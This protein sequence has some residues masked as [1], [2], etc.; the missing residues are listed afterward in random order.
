MRFFY[1]SQAI[2]R[3]LESPS[4]PVDVFPIIT[5]KER[6]GDLQRLPTLQNSCV[7]KAGAREGHCLS[8][9]YYNVN[10]GAYGDGGD[11]SGGSSNNNRGSP[12][13]KGANTAGR[14]GKVREAG[15]M[16]DRFM[17]SSFRD[18]HIQL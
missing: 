11:D 13:W 9:S 10:R 17:I 7:L 1:D 3:F 5:S 6:P 15:R 2:P 16:N 18:A 8:T 4:Q 14:E 12:K